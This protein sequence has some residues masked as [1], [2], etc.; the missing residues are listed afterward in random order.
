MELKR[1]SKLSD[2]NIVKLQSLF[3]L[4]RGSFQEIQGLIRKSSRFSFHAP[5]FYPTFASIIC[6]E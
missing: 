5:Y 1:L 3:P 4:T 2:G 6:N